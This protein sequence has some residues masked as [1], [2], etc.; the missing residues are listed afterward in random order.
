MQKYHAIV[1]I[2]LCLTAIGQ[3]EKKKAKENVLPSSPLRLYIDVDKV[4]DDNPMLRI[5]FENI[6]KKKVTILRRFSPLQAFFSFRLTKEDGTPKEGLCAARISMPASSIKY[7]TLEP[8]EFFGFK[9]RLSDINDSKLE[10][11]KYTLTVKYHNQYGENCYQGR[12]KSNTIEFSYSANK[13]SKRKTVHASE[14]S[15]TANTASSKKE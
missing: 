10:S 8:D 5:S 13:G 7:I 2:L 12:I 11:G 1:L 3:T 14:P 4:I 9:V 15:S 6:S